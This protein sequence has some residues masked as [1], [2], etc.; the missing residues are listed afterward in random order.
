[1]P[2][3]VT[4]RV[5]LDD[6]VIELISNKNIARMIKSMITSISFIFGTCDPSIA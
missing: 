6:A 5:N 1:M 3:D 4:R 2:D